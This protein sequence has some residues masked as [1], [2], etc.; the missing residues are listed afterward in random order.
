MEVKIFRGITTNLEKGG[1]VLEMR[2]GNYCYE[3]SVSCRDS[4][5][6]LSSTFGIVCIYE[7]TE[8]LYVPKTFPD[9]QPLDTWI[10]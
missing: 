4:V 2:G 8:G 3:L 7:A 10:S 5:Y 9:K 6:I 1:G